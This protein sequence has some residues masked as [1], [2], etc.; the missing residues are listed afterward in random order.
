ML[1]YLS[2]KKNVKAFMLLVWR[3][4]IASTQSNVTD[5]CS[6]R[7]LHSWNVKFSHMPVIASSSVGEAVKIRPSA[8]H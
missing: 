1:S 2:L 6:Q 5:I 8:R 7:H 4:K 3:E